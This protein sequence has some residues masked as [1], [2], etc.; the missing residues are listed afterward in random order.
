LPAVSYGHE[1]WSLILREEHRLKVIGNRVPRRIFEPKRDW[2]KL[3]N[4]ELYNLYS[5]PNIV[6]IIKARRMRWSGH[7]ARIGEKMILVRKPEGKRLLGRPK[8][9]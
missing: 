8:R 6:R 2:G 5:S 7:G 3:H 4:E 1:T 9:K